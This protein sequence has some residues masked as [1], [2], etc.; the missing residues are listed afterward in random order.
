[1]GGKKAETEINSPVIRKQRR[2][3]QY[4]EQQSL[5][6]SQKENSASQSSTVDN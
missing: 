2:N 5:T 6:I 1:M 4:Q 3:F